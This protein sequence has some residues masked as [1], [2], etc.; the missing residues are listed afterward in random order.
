MFGDPELGAVAA[1]ALG[2]VGDHRAVPHLVRLM[3]ADSDE[4]RLAEAFKVV[5]RAGADPQSSVAAAR[6]ILAA[7]PD[8]CVPVLPMR[9][10][11]AFGPA[12]V[13]AVPELIARL[14]GPRTTPRAV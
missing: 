6:Q 7:L 4:P 11:A 12:A 1:I 14:R 5:A 8:S 10:L 3:L 2:S 9:V 13:A